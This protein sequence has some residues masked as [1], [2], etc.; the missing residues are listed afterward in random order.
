MTLPLERPA[1]SEQREACKAAIDG[2]SRALREL[3]KEEPA[4]PI[5]ER[6]LRLLARLEQ[7]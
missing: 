7:A 2:I 3:W 1:S 5:P 6:L 4:A